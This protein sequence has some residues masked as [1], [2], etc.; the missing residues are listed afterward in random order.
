MMEIPTGEINTNS[1]FMHLQGGLLFLLATVA[2]GAAA[3][4]YDAFLN[5]MLASLLRVY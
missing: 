4:F 5:C 2:F 1:F 3:V